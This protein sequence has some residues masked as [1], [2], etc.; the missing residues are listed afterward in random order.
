[1][2][3][4]GVVIVL[5][6]VQL[7]CQVHGIP[8][9]YA[10]KIFTPDLSDQPFDKRGTSAPDSEISRSLLSRYYNETRTHLALNKDAPLSRTVK[11]PGRI[12]CRPILGGLHHEYIRV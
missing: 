7:P 9:E 1:M 3:A 12:L 10:V 6:F 2:N 5:V 4:V 11:T 8:E